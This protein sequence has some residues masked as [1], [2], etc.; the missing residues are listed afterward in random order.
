M[1]TLSTIY[2]IRVVLGIG[3]AL[4]CVALNV[5][6]IFTGISLGLLFY[7]LTNY[8]LKWLFIAKVQDSSKLLTTGI[9]IYFLTWIVAWI[10][11]YTIR[12]AA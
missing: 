9:G 7:I 5:E 1:E 4:I 6:D 2:W 3:A 11:L 8:I 12:I 10:L